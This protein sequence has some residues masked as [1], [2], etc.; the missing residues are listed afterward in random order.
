V[1]EAADGG[2][3]SLFL[4]GNEAIAKGAIAAGGRFYAGYPITPSSEIAEICSVRLPEIGGVYIQMEDELASMAAIIGASLAGVKS[5]TATSGP[6]FSLMQENLGFAV[7]GEVPCVVI[8]VQR[9]GPS[10]GLATKPAQADVMQARWGRHGDQTLIVLTPATVQECFELTVTSFN[11]A[12]RFRVP[13]ILLADEIV[14]HMRENVVLP[15]ASGIK[16]VQR[17]KPD[18]LPEEYLPFQPDAEGIAPLAEYGSEYVFHVT[19]SMHGTRGYSQNDPVNAEAKIKRLYSKLMNYLDEIVIVKHHYNSSDELDLLIITFG[20]TTR[21]ARAAALRTGSFRVG[22][23]QLVTLWP[24]PEE[25]IAAAARSAQV[26]LVPEMNLGQIG[27]EV[28]RVVGREKV[29]SLLKS[30][31]EGFSPIEISARMEEVAGLAGIE[32]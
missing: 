12:E 32:R 20:C 8:D 16:I 1:I 7:M 19:S 9:S 3:G 29:F 17:K 31:G 24:F 13:V 22:V 21:P 23:L 6:G 2:A 15:N 30:N 26:V 11:L 28:Q 18:C 27:Y 14:A 25:L 10:T 5:F 4:Q